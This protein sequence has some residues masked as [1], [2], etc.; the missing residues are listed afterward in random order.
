MTVA[1]VSVAP[2]GEA[3][4]LSR[5]PSKTRCSDRVGRPSG[6]TAK[7][8]SP[9]G[10]SGV[11]P[12]GPRG[13]TRWTIA[14]Q[15]GVRDNDFHG[16]GL[17]DLPELGDVHLRA[18]LQDEHCLRAP[19]DDD[20][21]GDLNAIAACRAFILDEVRAAISGPADE[22]VQA[23]VTLQEG[24]IVVA[25]PR[26][27]FH[28]GRALHAIQDGYAHTLRSDDFSVI[29][30]VFNY[31]DPALDPA[32]VA[33]RDGHRHVSEYDTCDSIDPTAAA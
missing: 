27:A 23:Q 17:A 24:T 7:C 29:A 5:S 16:V 4:A 14:L 13:W 28:M 20:Q 19:S 30:A 21:Q 1:G 15:L 32:Y 10:L 11:P 25:L 31:V 6:A 18:D 2:V 9:T 8:T 12:V 26:Y 33:A 22:P 3:P